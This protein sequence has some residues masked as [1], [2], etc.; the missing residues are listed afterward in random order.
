MD[1][2]GDVKGDSI[3]TNFVIEKDQ[4]PSEDALKRTAALRDEDIVY[5]DDCPQ[6]TMTMR[7]EL[8]QAVR[9]RNRLKRED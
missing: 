5:D 2:T 4:K 1:I 9:Q 7:K 6:I 8:A 3:M